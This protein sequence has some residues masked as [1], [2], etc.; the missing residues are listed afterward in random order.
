[1]FTLQVL[2]PNNVYIGQEPAKLVNRNI[3]AAINNTIAKVPDIAFVKYKT[4]IATT[5]NVLKILSK[6]DI[7]FFI[8]KNLVAKITD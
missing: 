3:P 8:I 2:I 5:T 4:V 7:F 6:A 1:M